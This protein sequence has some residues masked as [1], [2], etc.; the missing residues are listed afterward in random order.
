[1]PIKLSDIPKFEK[2]I[3]LSIKVF[4]YNA[5]L[6]KED[7]ENEILY[8]NPYVDII[9]RSKNPK[10]YPVNLLVLEN[11]KNYHYTGVV[12]LD[13]LL[14]L[15]V[16]S[17]KCRIQR[18]W[19]IKCLHG[20]YSKS[21]FEKHIALCKQ[22]TEKT[23]L[24]TMPKEKELNFKDYGK[25][26]TPAFVIYADT[27]AILIPDEAGLVKHVPIAVGFLLLPLLDMSMS[28]KYYSF[29]GESCMIQ[30]LQCID[31]LVKNTIEP[32]YKKNMNKSLIIT[33][34][35]E[36]QFMKS[37]HCY[38]CKK[39]SKKLVRDHDHYSGNFREWYV[40]IEI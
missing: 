23:T 35:E 5:N 28:S 12:N 18:K 40:M 11:D 13:R 3:N 37:T 6:N 27:E 25:T 38:L 24:Y 16:Q 15:N 22:I 8:K 29:S 2:Q 1:M 7:L 30:F 9:F 10:G 17:I 19:C 39:N 26:M 32:W 36:E 31:Q 20:F 4:K 33:T 34:R 21:T 14:N